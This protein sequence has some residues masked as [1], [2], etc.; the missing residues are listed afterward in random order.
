MKLSDAMT[1]GHEGWVR[2]P[3]V[4]SG[5]WLQ[6]DGPYFFKIADPS[7]EE[8]PLVAYCTLQKTHLELDD[9]EPK[10]WPPKPVEAEVWVSFDGRIQN[11][12]FVP[13]PLSKKYWRKTRVREVAP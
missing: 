6:L 11:I 10:P 2:S 5:E 12:E 1:V 7:D 8:S 4:H 9:W 3:A 13:G